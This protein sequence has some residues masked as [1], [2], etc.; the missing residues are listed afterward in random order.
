MNTFTTALAG[1][2]ERTIYFLKKRD[3]PKG[4]QKD[5]LHLN[6][7]SIKR[8]SGI[9]RLM[10]YLNMHTGD[11]HHVIQPYVLKR[12]SWNE[13]MEL[14]GFDYDSDTSES[15]GSTGDS[16]TSEMSNSQ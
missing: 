11:A 15:S 4:E 5:I 13:A 12:L 14:F 8:I 1:T 7:S 10:V 2:P 16:N 9:S 6:C 3:V